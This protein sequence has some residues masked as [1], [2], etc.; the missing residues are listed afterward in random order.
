MGMLDQ[1]KKEA[2]RNGTKIQST[3][4]RDFEAKL[5]QLFYKEKNIQK[6][7]QFLKTV[8]TRGQETQERKG[9]HASAIIVSDNKF[10]YRQQVLSLIYKQKQG[11]QVNVGLRRIF[12][13]GDAIHEKWQRLFIRGGYASPF[14][15][16]NTQFADEYEL[17]FT[18]DIICMID[19]TEM[20][21]EIKSVNTFQFQ[22][23]VKENKEH[24]S[25]KKQLNLYMGLTGIHKGFT[26]CED[27]NTQDF[28]VNLYDY[29]KASARPYIERLEN[30]Q[31]YKKNL[32]E[33]GK[34]VKRHEKCTGYTC[35]MAMACPMREVCYNKRKELL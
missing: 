34:L 28:K 22:K 19:G 18:P 5:N 12:A 33:K 27:K 21:G 6:E 16:D 32:L 23:M 15:L 29:D 24:E 26:L 20:V 35:K 13:E 4:Q 8:M 9:L 7:L 30:V 11:E 1:I 17:S 31:K 10:C 2:A 25:G 3:E 14:D